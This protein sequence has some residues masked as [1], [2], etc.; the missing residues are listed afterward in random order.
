MR[1]DLHQPLSSLGLIFLFTT[2]GFLVSSLSI[3]RLLPRTGFRASIVPAMVLYAFGALLIGIAP[4]L[5]VL[6]GGFL[7]GLAVGV[8]DGGLNLYSTLRMSGGIMQFLHGSWGV[9]TLFGPLLV[10][11]LLLS[12]MGWR[13]AFVTVAV[14]ELA[15]SVAVLLGRPWPSLPVPP[16]RVRGTGLKLSAPLLVGVLAFLVYTGAESAAGAW[17]YTVLTQARGFDP[18]PAGILV[19]AYWAGLTAGRVAAGVAGLRAS[20]RA[21]LYAGVGLTVAASFLFWLGPGPLS[22]VIALPLLGLGLAPIYPALMTLTTDRLPEARVPAAVGYQ[23]AAAGFGGATLPTGAGVLMQ[24]FGVA[25][26][27]PLLAV[28]SLLLACVNIYEARIAA[29]GRSN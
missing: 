11:A 4:W 2:A 25:V 19:S 16:R 20:P 5:G 17:S 24:T 26:F 3:G 1:S 12:Q 29:R 21:L 22:T 27:G 23:T 15:L 10:T 14:L 6:L 7:L 9:G 18:A 13:I 8:V 28:S